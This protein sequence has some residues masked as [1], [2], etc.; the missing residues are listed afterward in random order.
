LNFHFEPPHVGC[1]ARNAPVF[2]SREARYPWDPNPG[3]P[4]SP[5]DDFAA[6]EELINKCGYHRRDEELADA[7]QAIL[8]L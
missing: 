2:F 4:R 8:G 5:A 7:K 3:T 6:A 1:Y